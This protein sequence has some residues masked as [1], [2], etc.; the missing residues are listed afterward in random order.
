MSE[1]AGS[2]FQLSVVL[3]TV[4]AGSF[5]RP[6]GGAVADRIGAP[7]TTTCAALGLLGVTLWVHTTKVFERL[8]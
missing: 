5:V 4:F 7:A 3:A 8:D 1:R 6:V 2:E